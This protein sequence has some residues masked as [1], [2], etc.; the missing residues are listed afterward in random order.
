MRRQFWLASAS[1]VAMIAAF[2]LAARADDA[3]VA[4]MLKQMQERLDKQ[5]S[6][7]ASQKAEIAR[8]KGALKTK[9]QATATTTTTTRGHAQP[10][11]AMASAPSSSVVAVTAA[12]ASAPATQG[13]V[14]QL[15]TEL[16]QQRIAQQEQ[17]LWSVVNLR[18]TVSSPDGRFTM[19]LRGQFQLDAANYFQDPPGPL[20]SDFR[21]G[22]VG[23]GQREV[24]SARE[25]SD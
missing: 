8:L 18:P 24:N 22:S 12:D 15:R 14:Q 16:Q 10:Q 13:E 11:A 9:P 2:P 7:L 19:S 5:E 6:E 21:R 20:A 3:E 17:P 4:K 25:L 1:A 23:A